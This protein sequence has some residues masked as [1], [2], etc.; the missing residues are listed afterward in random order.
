MPEIVIITGIR[1]VNICEHLFFFPL[2]LVCTLPVV[3][4]NKE[5]STNSYQWE[6]HFVLVI[7]EHCWKENTISNIGLESECVG[8][9]NY[10]PAN[11]QLSGVSYQEVTPFFN[12]LL[13][14]LPH[15]MICALR[16]LQM[17]NSYHNFRKKIATL[18]TY[19]KNPRN[20][21]LWRNPK[22]EISQFSKHLAF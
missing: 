8:T 13:C 12:K 6:Q 18:N 14:L 3:C 11:V 15:L 9:Q 5:F 1:I 4:N 17:L 7:G 22:T 21:R 20:L 16:Q 2:P 19:C 10:I